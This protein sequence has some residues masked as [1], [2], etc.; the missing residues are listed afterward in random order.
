MSTTTHRIY[1]G[2]L[3]SIV[4]VVLILLIHNGLSYYRSG[5]DGRVV[6]P[7]HLALRSSGILGHGLGIAGSLSIIAG[8]AG[9][10]IRKRSRSLA[11][12]G[13]LKYWLEFHIFLC[14]LGPVL[15]LFHTAF[16]FGGLVAVSFWSMTAVFLSGIAG[17]F[18]YIRIPRSVEGRVLTVNEIREMKDDRGKTLI[19]EDQINRTIKRLDKMQR[20]FGYWHVVHLPFAIVMLIIML[21]HV[22]VT[23]L[24]GY[25]WIF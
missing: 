5:V 8:V 24:F 2:I 19:D 6:H 11:R 7:D 3:V 21:I 12:T 23:V 4:F 22:G 13:L 20:L 17:R 14:T 1:L 25:R 9:Y 16:K 10:M 18:I 15:I